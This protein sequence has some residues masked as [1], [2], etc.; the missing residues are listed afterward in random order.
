MKQWN[1][2]V[3]LQR[4]CM[5]THNTLQ[6][7]ATRC[8][9]L[10]HAAT[11]CNTLQ[12]T[13]AE[14]HSRHTWLPK[15]K[16]RVWPRMSVRSLQHTATHCNTLQHTTIHCNTPQHGLGWAS[17]LSNTLQHTATQCNT[18]HMQRRRCSSPHTCTNLNI[19]YLYMCIY[20]HLGMD[21]CILYDWTARS[22]SMW[23]VPSHSY[24]YSHSRVHART[25]IHECTHS[26]TRH[27]LTHTHTHAHT[28]VYIHHSKFAEAEKRIQKRIQ[29]LEKLNFRN[30]LK[31][32]LSVSDTSEAS[33]RAWMWASQLAAVH[34]LKEQ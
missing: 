30:Q 33:H 24:V 17:F 9:T 29:K 20:I 31:S 5:H 8:N 7:A 25:R 1:T 28:Y 4:C 14:V 11:R 19:L 26:H 6:H 10:Q 23:V 13:A 22:Q 34:L 15:K 27:T 18:L 16:N 2:Y 21:L 12:H 32:Y 3:C